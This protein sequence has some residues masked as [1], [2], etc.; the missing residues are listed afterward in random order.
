MANQFCPYSE[1]QLM[2]K[3]NCLLS[4]VDASLSLKISRCKR[5]IRF[6]NLK[7][8]EKRKTLT[9]MFYLKTYYCTK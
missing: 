3:I 9:N 1:L 8:A 4:C 6:I 2:E 5:V 7:T